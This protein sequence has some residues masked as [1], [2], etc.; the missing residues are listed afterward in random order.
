MSS[1]NED[2]Q[3]VSDEPTGPSSLD[4]LL[5]VNEGYNV[6]IGETDSG[7]EEALIGVVS[8]NDQLVK[9]YLDEVLM[10]L[11]AARGGACGQ[12]LIQDLYRLGCGL[13][14]G[15]VYPHLHDLADEDILEM[16]E[17][18]R[19]K[20]FTIRNHDEVEQLIRDTFRDLEALSAVLLLSDSESSGSDRPLDR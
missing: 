5:E 16:H 20:Q 17:Q 12:E 11:I 1:E 13:S 9:A 18:C 19:T 7:I 10:V 4:D 8:L 3:S 2:S 15:T 14:P 6:G